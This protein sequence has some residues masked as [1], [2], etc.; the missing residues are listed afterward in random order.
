MVGSATDIAGANSQ[1]FAS[2]GST[3]TLLT[4]LG[5]GV[6]GI[7]NAITNNALTNVIVGGDEKAVEKYLSASRP[8]DGPLGPFLKT[9]SVSKHLLFGG[10][11]FPAEL[12]ANAKKDPTSKAFLPLLEAKS[13]EFIVVDEQ[14]LGALSKIHF[15][16]AA[17]A[18]E[19]T[20]LE[21]TRPGQN[22]TSAGETP[23]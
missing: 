9:A 21:G 17:K 20:G 13:S 5:T 3:T 4:N 22:E 2:D 10:F 18:E 14:G 19:A 6:I 7:A 11:H 23:H 15:E 1:A 8:K 16:D 12:V